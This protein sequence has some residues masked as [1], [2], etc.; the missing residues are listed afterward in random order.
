MWTSTSTSDLPKKDS[1]V[2]SVVNKFQSRSE[3]GIKKYGVTLDREDLSTIEWIDHLQCELMDA[4]LYAEKIKQ[5]IV[6]EQQVVTHYRDGTIE[7]D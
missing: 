3:V 5:L 4:I 6:K 2:E 7:Y 1:I